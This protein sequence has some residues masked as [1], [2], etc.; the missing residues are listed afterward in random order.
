MQVARVLT[1]WRVLQEGSLAIVGDKCR[2]VARVLTHWRVL[3]VLQQR[4]W[5]LSEQ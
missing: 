5:Q 3:Q 1:H 2:V 4:A